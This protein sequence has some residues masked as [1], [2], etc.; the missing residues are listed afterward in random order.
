MAWLKMI[1]R[2]NLKAD[3]DLQIL[4]FA[5]HSHLAVLAR[6]LTHDEFGK[7]RLSQSLL[8]QPRYVNASENLQPVSDLIG[9][10][11][12]HYGGNTIVNTFRRSGVPYREILF[13]VCG[14]LWLKIDKKKTAIEIEDDVLDLLQLLLWEAMPQTRRSAFVA[15][16]D[17][18]NE[19][20]PAFSAYIT[21]MVMKDLSLAL[22]LGAWLKDCTSQLVW[23][24]FLA[25]LKIPYLSGTVTQT[26][27]RLFSSGVMPWPLA[28]TGPALTITTP[29]VVLIA[30]LRRNMNTD[31]Y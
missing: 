13:D 3:L 16:S 14:S 5:D 4:Q 26:A 23:N 29:A 8:A 27:A 17:L 12:Q 22:T 21:D 1:M 10:E 6:H 19:V 7:I 9:A 15:A 18:P 2:I 24:Y 31:I 11:L 30:F 25:P 28:I 20:P